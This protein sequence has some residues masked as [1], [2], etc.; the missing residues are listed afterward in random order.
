MPRLSAC[1]LPPDC[2][3]PC[4]SLGQTGAQIQGC[5]TKLGHYLTS[6]ARTRW[7]TE[8][9]ADVRIPSNRVGGG[10]GWQC[11]VSPKAYV[12]GLLEVQTVPMPTYKGL[13]GSAK[14]P[15]AHI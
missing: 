4:F 12:G 13:F 14:C 2:P 1:Y 10:A 9:K 8:N 11:K 15:H 3:N 7:S 6:T 5:P